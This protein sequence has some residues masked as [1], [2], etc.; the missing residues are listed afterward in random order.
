MLRLD[1]RMARVRLP[2]RHRTAILVAAAVIA[3]V[4]VAGTALAT[5][6]PRRL[7]EQR[8]EFTHGDFLAPVADQRQRLTTV[9]NNGRL[10]LWGVAWDSFQARP[11]LGTGAGT[12]RLAWERERPAPP[13]KANDAHSLYVEVLG[14]LG[15]PGLVLLL[16]ALAT[17]LI[18]AATRLRR[19]ERG[20]YAA[21]LALGAMLVVHAGVDWDWEMPALFVWFFAA[22]GVVLA[23]PAGVRHARSPSRLTRIVLGL[24]CLLV[25]VNPALIVLSQGPLERSAQA[26]K[27][28][29]C[30]VAID[31]ALDSTEVLS[32]R[33]E[34]YEVLG[35]CDAHLGQL[36]LAER[37]MRSARER[38]PDNW[39]YAYGLAVTQALAGRDP[40]EMARLVVRLNPLSALAH[41]FELGVRRRDPAK[42]KAVAVTA[43]PPFE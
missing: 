20:A 36:G 6:A 14:E 37:A 7:D 11:L 21:F 31:A 28:A 33:P 19:P 35:W 22:A 23:A 38:D 39:Q 18:V 9:G 43:P 29:D 13:V 10:A 25:A 12:W 8:R 26:F 40:R 27:R 41:D 32:I 42:W 34:P 16:V 1:D 17:P 24:G 2:P 5:D 15:V 3:A 4:A 30:R